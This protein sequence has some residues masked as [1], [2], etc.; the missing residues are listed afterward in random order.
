VSVPML[1]VQGTRDALADPAL[2]GPLT[3]ALGATL[4]TIDHADHSFHVPVRSGRT[5]S[6]VMTQLLDETADW[7]QRILHARS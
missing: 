3:A 2:I 6:E 7:M 4:V 5:D 1:F